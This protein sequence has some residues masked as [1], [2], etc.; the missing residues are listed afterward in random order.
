MFHELVPHVQPWPEGIRRAPLDVLLAEADF[1]SIHVTLSAETRGLLSAR[2][3]G[4]MKPGSILVNTSRGEIV[5]EVALL[6]ALRTGQ[7]RGA[8]LDV[9]TGEPEIAKH[10]LVEHARRDPNLIITPHI[11]G[12]SPDAVRQVLTFSCERIRSFFGV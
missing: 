7:L 9:L 2:E 8:G 11:G 6:E 12:F 1:V 3:I 10:P 5:D 4:L